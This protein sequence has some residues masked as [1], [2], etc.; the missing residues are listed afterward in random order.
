MFR[1]INPFTEEQFGETPTLLDQELEKK[2]SLSMHAFSAWSHL[3]IKEKLVF[4]QNL[5]TIL[6]EEKQTLSLLITQ[7]MGKPLKQSLTE[8]EKCVQLCEYVSEQAPAFLKDKTHLPSTPK[9][10]YVSFQPLGLILGIMPWNFPCWQVFRFALPVLLGGNTVLVKHAPNVMLCAVQLE[11]LFL[12]AGFPSGVYQNLPI[13]IEQTKKVISDSRIQ[14]VSLTGSVRAGRAVATLSGQYLKKTV[15][16][17]GGSDP[18][19]ILDSADL[20]LAS[21]ECVASRMNNSGQSCISAKRFIVTSQNAKTFTD[22]I[23]K[24]MKQYKMGDPML[25]DTR[26]GPLARADLRE[27]LHKQVSHLKKKGACALLG[28][29]LP[30]EK[31]YFYP[32]TILKSDTIDNVFDFKE[33]LFG[34]VAWMIF[35]PDEKSALRTANASP[36]GLGSAIF[37]RDTKKAERW[38]RNY[39][40]AGSSVVNQALHSHSALPFGGIKDSGYGRELSGYGFYEFMNVK[41]ISIAQ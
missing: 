37:C 11:A 39:L 40:Q 2:L 30:K 33:E 16:E 12:K 21:A 23:V 31:G 26:L 18:Y 6:R 32:P 14:G 29:Y 36:Y 3:D 5:K 13:S 17:L 19:V 38:A 20:D 24:K 8:V 34:P 1:S 35:V 27:N 15:L 9:N 10:S 22:L 28:A 7:E 4:V 41:T 25:P